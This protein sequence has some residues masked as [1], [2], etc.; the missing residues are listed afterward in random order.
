MKIAITG[1]RPDAFLVSHYSK[2]TIMRIAS[3]IV[4][5]FK[6]EFGDDLQFN[7]GGAI[8]IDQWIGMACMEQQVK[9]HLYLPFIREVQSKYWSEEQKKELC[10]QTEHAIGIDIVDTSGEYQAS[11][12]Q[13]RNIRMVDSSDYVVAFWVGKRRG[14]TFNAIKYALSKSK[15]V[16]NALNELK[17]IFKEDLKKGWTPP[18]I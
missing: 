15:F 5:V 1:H 6:R 9:F 18:I 13:E 16:F 8:G 11:K 14:G 2:E 7:L 12:Y 3:D 4:C 10:R 17:P